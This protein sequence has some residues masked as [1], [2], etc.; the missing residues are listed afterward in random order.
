MHFDRRF[1]RPGFPGAMPDATVEAL[2]RQA[3]GRQ[4]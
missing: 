1:Y 4:A 2:V 3:E